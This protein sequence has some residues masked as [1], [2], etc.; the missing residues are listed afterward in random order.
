M[1][2]AVVLARHAPG[3]AGTFLVD[4]VRSVRSPKPDIGMRSDINGHAG[5]IKLSLTK[6]RESPGLV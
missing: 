4:F 3:L 1:V 6:R 2:Q 5:I